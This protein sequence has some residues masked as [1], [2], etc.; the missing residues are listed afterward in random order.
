MRAVANLVLRIIKPPQ[1]MC[2]TPDE[3]LVDQ[4]AR[5]IAAVTVRPETGHG[6]PREQCEA[7]D[8]SVSTSRP[9][10]P[11]GWLLRQWW[12]WWEHGRGAGGSGGSA[13]PSAPPRAPEGLGGGRRG[14]LAS[15]LC[16]R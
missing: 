4:F 2:I 15:Q 8:E 6:R 5:T 13:T 12:W 9:P 10:S 16:I 11:L 14:G 1:P 7:A 3:Q